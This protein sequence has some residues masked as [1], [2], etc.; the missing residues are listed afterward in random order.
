MVKRILFVDDN[1][2]VLNIYRQ[3]F[4]RKGNEW[5][6]F[7]SSDAMGAI[8]I[9]EYSQIDMIITDLD[10][11][12]YNGAQLLNLVREK[13]PAVTRIVFS[14]SRSVKNNMQTVNCAHRFVAKPNTVGD[15]ERMIEKIFRLY[16]QLVDPK[17]R[18]VIN[19]I[20]RLPAL[21]SVYLDLLEEFSLPNFSLKKV[22]TLI[23]GD[24]GMTTEIL[25]MV[26]SAYFGLNESVSSPQQ[27]VT[28]LGGDIVK[29]LILTAHIS[30]SLTKE[31][32]AF[33]IESWENHSLLCGIFCQ[34]IAQYEKKT[35]QE[36]DTAFV[37][38]I[39]HDVGRI[40]LATSFAEKYRRVLDIA[41]STH[42]PLQDVERQ[43]LNTTH[44][45]VGAYLLGL[46]GLPDQIVELTATH[47]SPDQYQGESNDLVYMLHAAD[48][49]TYELVPEFNPGS[50][51]V[52]ERKAYS[53][54]M[55]ARVNEWRA[56]CA[57][58]GVERGYLESG[59]VASGSSDFDLT[60]LGDADK[61]VF[62]HGYDELH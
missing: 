38:G 43:V 34:A 42:Q 62:V 23:S 6:C 52:P 2:M 16:R 14:G 22:G 17:T 15:L 33:S 27:A 53:P 26:N 1:E 57:K 37:S 29:G 49:L 4:S 47:H 55:E 39:L 60:P 40:I 11:P 20:D 24:V 56:Y 31:E 28:L 59:S 18:A 32:Q 61:G 35:Q 36:Q 48:M 45:A 51:P 19:G 10:M 3:V 30:R 50:L 46:W 9:L 25:K 13:Y 54:E 21:P 12:M 58:V 8:D 7:Y 41:T 5:Q 44:S